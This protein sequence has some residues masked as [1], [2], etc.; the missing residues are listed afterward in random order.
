[1]AQKLISMSQ[2]ELSRYEIIT[3][4]IAQKINGTMAAK[5]LGL[6][7]RQIQNLKARVKKDGARGLVHV[8]RGRESNRKTKP[9]I[10]E[11]VKE[12]LKEKY[13][14]FG[15]KF[16]SEK[17]EENYEI[18]LGK[19]TIRQIMI[20][21]KLWKPK[22]RKTN[23]EYRAWRPRKEQYG[24]MEQF[25]GS[26]HKWF[27]DRAPECCLLTAVDDAT[28]KI[29]HAR[30]DHHEGVIPVFNFW[31]SYVETRG[32]PI[33]VYLDKFSTY[34]INHK[35][36]IDNQYLMTQ[37]QRAAMDLGID[38]ITAH[39]PQAKGRIERLFETL[40]DRL[41]KEMRLHNI[42]D[43]ETAN[44]FL[45]EKYIPK[46]NQQFSVPSQK[47][48]DLHKKITDWE[49]QDLE[50]IFAIQ[51]TRIVNNDFTINFK[52][53]WLQ[54]DQKQPTLVLKKNAV[55]IEERL[56]GS[57]H[58]SLRKKYLNFK[59]LPERPKKIID[60]KLPALT[61]TKPAWI[62]PKDH[63]WRQRILYGKFKQTAPTL[64]TKNP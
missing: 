23:K 42:S 32:K 57:I 33:A 62:P 13:Y 15:P 7:V 27:E 34:K 11:K 64:I 6:T 40:Q 37:F 58:I 2:K 14:D 35:A 24:E 28:G 10:I 26:Y 30:F 51:N 12:Y 61:K 20:A 5:L 55:M 43:I 46:F 4:L 17:L 3:Q 53:R 48:G 19:E 41:I 21:E 8:S 52:T 50:K 54:L 22:L 25:D 31:K 59:E 9:E 63:P 39:S 38:L 18:K 60:I 44:K 56:D 16:A 45:D 29:T 47:K 36:A 1:M 49:K